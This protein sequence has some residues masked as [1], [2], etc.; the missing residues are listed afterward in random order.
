MV[1]EGNRTKSDQFRREFRIL[2][3][4][5]R[6]HHS[7]AI[8]LDCIGVALSYI[9][10]PKV[11]DWVQYMLNKV[12]CT[13]RQGV[14]PEDEALWE[15]FIRDFS[16][17]FTDTTKVQNVHQ[18]LLELQMQPNRLDDYISTFEHLCAL[19]GWGVDNASTIM[20]FKKGLTR[21][22]HK[23]MLKKV[24]PCLTMLRGWIEGARQQY[25]LWAEVR[26][27]LGGSFAK[28]ARITQNKS[29]KWRT[30]LGKKQG[31][32]K[33]VRQEDQ[34]DVN[35]MEVNALT[36]EEKMKLQKVLQFS[37]HAVPHPVCLPLRYLTCYVLE[38]PVSVTC[39]HEYQLHK[40][41]CLFH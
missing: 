3:L 21:G 17:S 16:L 25:K 28:P 38:V 10:G 22:L 19:V 8:P 24:V 20:L 35:T 5:N 41:D 40:R 4:S 1:F 32:W 14:Q 29:Q 12:E 2:M 36:T 15:M 34:M 26:A 9:R 7:L 37:P 39:D 23:A 30:T 33:G 6:N 11:D 13:L 27:S 18:E 31:G